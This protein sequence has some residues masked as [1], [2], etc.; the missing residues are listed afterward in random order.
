MRLSEVHWAGGELPADGLAA[1]DRGCP[2]TAQADQPDLAARP[3]PDRPGRDQHD[4]RRSLAERLARLPDA[5]P[6]AWS[7]A[8]RSA[9]ERSSADW[10]GARTGGE[11]PSEHTWWRG[12]SDIWWRI[13]DRSAGEADCDDDTGGLEDPGD[14]A[15]SDDLG[16]ADGPAEADWAADADD[17]AEAGDQGSGTGGRGARRAGPAPGSARPDHSTRD[18]RWGNAGLARL[19]QSGPDRGAYRPWFSADVP[20]DP[21]FAAGLERWADSS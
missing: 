5:H 4:G 9:A 6:S 21:W 17:T 11:P 10:A 19:D 16:D 15:D 14:L 2:V 8:A 7:V 18:G 13:P 20:G 1:D 3:G 12:E